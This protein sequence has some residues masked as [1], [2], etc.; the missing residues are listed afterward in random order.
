MCLSDPPNMSAV[1][2][3]ELVVNHTQR[4]GF[5]C[6]A[7]GIPVPGIM[8]IKVSDGS[9][10]FPSTDDIEITEVIVDSLKRVSNITFL[11][12]T[13]ADQSEYTCVGSNGVKNMIGSPE[14]VTV[15][16]LVQGEFVVMSCTKR[17]RYHNLSN[18]V[19]LR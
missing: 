3:L 16:L 1:E 19:L 12:T 2:P 5:T 15:N 13:R 4:A 6:E 17:A 14:N 11:N 10:I 8:W 7:F 9:M 18:G